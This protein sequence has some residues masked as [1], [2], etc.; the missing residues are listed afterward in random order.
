MDE[1]STP[2]AVI[3]TSSSTII[4]HQPPRTRIRHRL[5]TGQIFEFE[6]LRVV[7]EGDITYLETNGYI[8]RESSPEDTHATDR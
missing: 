6:V 8:I 2:S 3:T 1:S 4:N 5:T 7:Q